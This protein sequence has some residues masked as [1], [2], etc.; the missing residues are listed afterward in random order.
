MPRTDD[1]LAEIEAIERQATSF[2]L[3]GGMSLPGNYQ[4]AATGP[5]ETVEFVQMSN[6]GSVAADCSSGT[7]QCSTGFIDNGNGCEEMTEEQAATTTLAPTTYQPGSAGNWPVVLVDKLAAVF[8]DNRPDK[9]RTELLS[10]W[11]KLSK[12]FVK[13]YETVVANDCQFAENYEDDSVDFDSI[14]TCKVSFR[15]QL[16]FSEQD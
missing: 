5:I 12:K 16:K 6:D 1:I 7:C 10:K 11:K 13:R 15:K 8:A 4:V 9:P 14:N 3:D 2:I